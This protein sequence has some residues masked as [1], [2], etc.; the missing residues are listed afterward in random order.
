[1]QGRGSAGH[2]AVARRGRGCSRARISRGCSRWGCGGFIY[3][4]CVMCNSITGTDN[5][6]ISASRAE[7]VVV[8][9]F[10]ASGDI[11]L[12]IMLWAN[13][14]LA[15]NASAVTTRHVAIR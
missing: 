5:P 10:R 3:N 4:R 11:A 14:S 12:I 8:M 9:R 7:T 2:T 1:M 6:E 13:T 15:P